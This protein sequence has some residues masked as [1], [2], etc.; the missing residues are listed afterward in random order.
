MVGGRN[1]DLRLP[2][3][4]KL[5]D[6]TAS[7]GTPLKLTTAPLAWPTSSSVSIR[8]LAARRIQ[9]GSQSGPL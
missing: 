7:T 2:L 6:G 3:K 1:P 4:G 5:I 8:M 9:S